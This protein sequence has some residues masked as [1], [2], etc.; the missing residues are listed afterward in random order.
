MEI[1][2]RRYT[3]ACFCNRSGAVNCLFFCAEPFQQLCQ[4]NQ[5]VLSG[6]FSQFD[7]W[8]DLSGKK[9]YGIVSIWIGLSHIFLHTWD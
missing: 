4:D 6:D 9:C 8:Y 3:L 5:Y 2:L 1:C 7:S